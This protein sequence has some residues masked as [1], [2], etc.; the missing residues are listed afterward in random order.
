MVWAN[1]LVFLTKRKGWVAVRCKRKQTG[2]TRQL[3]AFK[4]RMLPIYK[5]E[6]LEGGKP[7]K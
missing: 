5:K 7:C 1:L 3:P 2:Q 4:G 6:R